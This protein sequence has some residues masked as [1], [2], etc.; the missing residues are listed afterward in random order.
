MKNKFGAL[1]LL[2][3][4]LFPQPAVAQVRRKTALVD[5][6]VSVFNDAGVSQSVLSK[7]QDRAT[8][9]MRRAGL[10]LVWLDCGTPGNR[11]TN[12]GCSAISFPEHLSV[13]LVSLLLLRTPSYFVPSNDRKIP[14]FPRHPRL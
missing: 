7:A 8:F 13:R 3:V 14:D 11:Q 6:T 9:I 1:S 5:L 12:T 4:S 10:F 2:L